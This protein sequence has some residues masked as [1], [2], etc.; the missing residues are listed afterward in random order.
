MNFSIDL[1][2]EVQSLQKKSPRNAMGPG[3]IIIQSNKE[4]ARDHA[5]EFSNKKKTGMEE[6]TWECHASQLQACKKMRI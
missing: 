2:A 5:K 1:V 3:I 6:D 4:V